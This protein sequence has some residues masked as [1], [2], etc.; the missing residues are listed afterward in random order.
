[1]KKR[2][3]AVSL[4]LA[5]IVGL[6][7]WL[8]GLIPTAQAQSAGPGESR[9]YIVKFRSDVAVPLAVDS[10]GESLGLGMYLVDSPFQAEALAKTGAV[11]F[12]EP[13]YIRYPLSG[14]LV[15]D[16]YYQTGY[17]WNVDFLQMGPLWEQGLS[18]EG[19]TVA[20][21][22]TGLDLHEDLDPSRILPGYN[23]VADAR[24]PEELM[25]V[26]A[27]DDTSDLSGHGTFVTGIIAA[28]TN[29][30]L[31]IAGLSP[32]VNILPCMV[33]QEGMINGKLGIGALSSD[34]TKAIIWATQNGADVI[35]LS[36]GS[37]SPDNATREAVDYAVSQGVIVVAAVG[38]DG[39]TI[40]NY[41]A[42]FDNVIGVG[43]L[44]EVKG[45]S[46]IG[47]QRASYSNYNNSVFVTAPGTR[48]FSLG[49]TKNADGTTT[50]TYY[51]QNGTSFSTPCVSALAAL[52]KEANP[53][54]NAAQFRN[55][56]K[57][58]VDDLGETGY[59]VEYGYGSVN[60]AHIAAALGQRSITYELNGGAWPEGEPTAAQ[61][62]FHTYQE[63]CSG[64]APIADRSLNTNART[65]LFHVPVVV[66]PIQFVLDFRVGDIVYRAEKFL[67]GRRRL[68]KFVALAIG[69]RVGLLAWFGLLTLTVSAAENTACNIHNGWVS[70]HLKNSTRPIL[71]RALTVGQLVETT[72]NIFRVVGK[73][74]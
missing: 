38:N 45:G 30:G 3:T 46:V 2:W 68:F 40:T 22:D 14:D 69:L 34:I 51:A 5:L 26:S 56:L 54:I 4:V 1:M 24:T 10:L 18:G 13:N 64:W 29:N 41:P 27:L 67:R 47:E 6:A 49:V 17:Q 53:A 73:E 62:A 66:K 25:G 9:G 44:G 35:N 15:N 72:D 74:V 11:E 16:R 12:I 28:Q 55:L 65:A 60:A 37:T 57:L 61:T 33:F 39:N 52:A 58:T 42:G 7:P 63:E 21:I 8:P 50:S 71:L 20:V 23:A 48:T 59:D 36:L 19:V 31:G 43:A 32:H 70:H